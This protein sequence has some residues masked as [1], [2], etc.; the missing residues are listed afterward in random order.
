MTNL[1]QLGADI[2]FCVNGEEALELVRVNLQSQAKQGND[3]V[4][5]YILM[6]C[7]VWSY[8]WHFGSQNTSLG[9][10]HL[11]NFLCFYQMP[12]MD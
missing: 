12:I 4:L 6:D 2:E 7:Q 9:F 5:P 10:F 3:F 8:D 1:S 11:L